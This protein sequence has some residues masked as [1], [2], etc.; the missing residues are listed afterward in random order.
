VGSIVSWYDALNGSI[1]LRDGLDQLIGGLGAEAA[2]LVRADLQDLRPVRIATADRAR[3]LIAPRPLYRSFADR[4]FGPAMAL[5]RPGSIWIGS[6]HAD[7]S[8]EDPALADW[9]ASRRMKEFVVLVLSAGEMLR[10]HIELHFRNRLSPDDEAGL[11][12]VMPDLVRVWAGRKTGLIAR[13]IVDHRLPELRGKPR[14]SDLHILSTDNP[15]HLSRAEFRVCLL[16]SQGLLTQAVALELNLTE[17]TI[18]T[19]LRNI[20]AKTETSCLAELVFR[21]MDGA[22]RGEESRAC[23]A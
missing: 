20:Y 21:L 2:M 23:Y 5:A 11:M 8:S 6:A 18:R 16:L 9:Q 12:A 10:D 1:S 3:G 13:S 19:H 17:A 15:A 4:Y 14:A 7:D 22:A